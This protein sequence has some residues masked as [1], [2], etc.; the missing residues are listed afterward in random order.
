M[1]WSSRTSSAASP[2]S[3]SPRRHVEFPDAVPA[4]LDQPLSGHEVAAGECL[5]LRNVHPKPMIN[6]THF[7]KALG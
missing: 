7:G 2:N 3:A 4:E 5:L 1:V 6:R